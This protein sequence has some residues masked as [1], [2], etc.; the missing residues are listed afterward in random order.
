MLPKSLRRNVIANEALL[1]ESVL[2]MDQPNVR[3]EAPIRFA[4]AAHRL[5]ESRARK[6]WPYEKRK[7]N[8]AVFV[9]V[10]RPR[11]I[12]EN[13]SLNSTPVVS[14]GSSG[15]TP[16]FG[17]LFLMN[18]DCS[19]GN[20]I[21]LPCKQNELL[22]WL[23]DQYL[24][25]WPL[26]IAYR[27]TSKFIMRYA[28]TDDVVREFNI[29]DQL[30][31]VTCEQL[32]KAL[33][34]FYEN[35]LQTPNRYARGIWEEGH[36]KKYIPGQN[37]ELCIQK[38]LVPGLDMWFNGC[39]RIS[40]EGGTSLGRYDIQLQKPGEDKMMGNWAIIELKI[41][42]T[43]SN[44]KSG[45]AP[46]PVSESTNIREIKKGLRQVSAYSDKTSSELAL[47][48]IFDMRRDK[49]N[50]LT[51]N[52]NVQKQINNLEP[53]P[54]YNTRKMYGSAEQARRDLYPES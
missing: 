17:N 54:I 4:L 34:V 51:Q 52:A 24:G 36:E 40:V 53:K 38:E 7:E 30:P 32:V 25:H 14:P 48:E 18:M 21:P 44:P 35:Y 5:L 23:D 26:A 43:Y 46:A 13:I 2:S 3:A 11:F 20:F 47:L 42:K 27:N 16:L 50:D 31:E 29:R 15:S 1:A 45:G 33:T 49:S 12:A 28:G 41:I 9:M 10:D 37:P 19:R 6:D 22:D 39:S 8:C